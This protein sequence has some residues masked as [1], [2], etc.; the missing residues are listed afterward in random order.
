MKF[1]NLLRESTVTASNSLGRPQLQALTRA[2]NNLIF[3]DLVAIQPT[4]VPISALYGLNYLNRDLT[5]TFLTPATYGGE[6]GDRSEID[7]VQQDHQYK[8]GDLFVSDD[9][10]YKVI[11][12]I[13]L[14]SYGAASI[15]ESLF[16]AMVDSKIRFFSDAASPSKF[17]DPK[18]EI[19][20]AKFLMHKWQ[21]EVKTRKLKTEYTN[22]LMEDLEANQCDSENTIID[23]LATTASE[24]INKDVIQKLIT[25]SRRYKVEGVCPDAILSLEDIQDA[26]AQARELYRYVCEMSAHMQRVTSFT[27]TYVL[28]SCRV[29]AMLQAS[30]WMSESDHPLSEGRLR[31]GLEVYSDTTATFDYVIVGCKH[32]IGEMEHVGSLFYSPYTEADGAGAYRAVIDPSSLQHKVAIMSRY[33]LSVNPYTVSND[34]DAHQI[35]TGDDWGALAGRSNMSLMLGVKL[36]KVT[37]VN[38]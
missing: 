14:N 3:S 23:L 27:G 34:F 25:V 26:P 5:P 33:S 1:H 7:V 22:E 29:V 21:V 10:V 36:P 17:E 31:C 32:Q 24:E 4:S 2:V 28:A 38:I 16:K 15:E 35:V 37:T 9:T 6:V 8:A 19:A 18:T 30:G 20:S 13:N 12:P 11:E